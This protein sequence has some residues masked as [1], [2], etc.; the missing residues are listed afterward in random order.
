MKYLNT[1]VLDLTELDE[2]AALLKRC[3]GLP[4]TLDL[5]GNELDDLLASTTCQNIANIHADDA[6][7]LINYIHEMIALGGIREED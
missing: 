6:R 2:L 3:H 1:G 4:H 5:T 7:T